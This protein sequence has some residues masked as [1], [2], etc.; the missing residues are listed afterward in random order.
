MTLRFSREIT[1]YEAWRWVAPV[2]ETRAGS[3][4]LTELDLARHFFA[5]SIRARLSFVQSRACPGL[6]SS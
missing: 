6:H 4:L 3:S 5:D 1:W 2:Y